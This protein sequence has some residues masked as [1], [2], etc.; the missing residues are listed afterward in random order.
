MRRRTTAFLKGGAWHRRCKRCGK[1]KPMDEFVL[2][3]GGNYL[4]TCLACRRAFLTAQGVRP[5][6]GGR[7]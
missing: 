7:W 2:H 5:R 3:W 1:E 6:K 4:N